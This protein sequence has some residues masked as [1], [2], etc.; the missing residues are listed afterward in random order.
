MYNTHSFDRNYVSQSRGAYYVHELIG[1][2]VSN[3]PHMSS[4]E[5]L[6]TAPTQFSA[7]VWCCRHA[8]INFCSGPLN[9]LDTSITARIDGRYLLLS[10]R[11]EHGRC[12]SWLRVW[13]RRLVSSDATGSG[14]HQA[15]RPTHLVATAQ[16]TTIS[17][18]CRG[19]NP[20]WPSP[21]ESAPCS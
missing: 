13:Q 14:S 5:R 12:E 4:A 18:Q 1:L 16:L 6:V 11:W 17:S 19:G 7:V 9:V 15:R 10:C 21:S 8:Q 3:I 20:Q 2:L